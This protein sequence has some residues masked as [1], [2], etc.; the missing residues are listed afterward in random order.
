[1]TSDTLSMF[2]EL[3]PC[4]A[5]KCGRPAKYTATTNANGTWHRIHCAACHIG[6]GDHELEAAVAKWRRM[7]AGWR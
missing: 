4:P 6:Q 2:G 3:P 7:C 5:A 1:M